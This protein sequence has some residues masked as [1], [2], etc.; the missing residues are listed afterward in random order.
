MVD[1]PQSPL[2]HKHTHTLFFLLRPLP[3]GRGTTPVTK[4]TTKPANSSRFSPAEPGLRLATGLFLLLAAPVFSYPVDFPPE[5][6]TAKKRSLARTHTLTHTYAKGETSAASSSSSLFSAHSVKSPRGRKKILRKSRKKNF[7][8]TMA[9]QKK[10]HFLGQ[11][12]VISAIRTGTHTQTRGR[13][14]KKS[15]GSFSLRL[16]CCSRN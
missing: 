14:E 11:I 13:L 5:V 1:F 16:T 6:F 4:F 8:Q 7:R 9:T 15:V 10:N 3:S 2:T 12:R